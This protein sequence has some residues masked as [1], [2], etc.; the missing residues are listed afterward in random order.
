[1]NFGEQLRE[2]RTHR[3]M[4]Q[5]DLALEAGISAKHLSFLETGR[6]RPTEGMILRLAQALDIPARDQ[7]LLFSAAGF[8]PRFAT[9]PAR[10]LDDF[11]LPVAQAIRLLL[12]RHDPFPGIVFDAEYNVLAANA[13]FANLAAA[14][15]VAF[16]PGDNFLEAYLGEPKLRT[17][18]RNWERTAADLVHRIRT[19]AW[20]QGPRSPLASRI[21]RLAVLSDVADALEHFPE[22]DRLPVLPI[23]MEI[24]GKVLSWIT[25]LT[26]FGSAQDALVQGVTIES[27]FPADE[28]TRRQFE[29]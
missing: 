20:L 15:G 18:I 24:G 11:P 21:S 25:T 2:W 13:A 19:E 12:A 27:F 1:M 29:H 3:R 5:L 26:S 4:S 17:L 23:E 6:A 14:A 9:Q 7:G 22:S 10:S 28:E 16:A 8:R